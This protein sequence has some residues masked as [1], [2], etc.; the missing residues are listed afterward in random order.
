MGCC[1]S[2]VELATFADSKA[3]RTESAKE[4]AERQR[5]EGKAEAARLAKGEASASEEG[6]HAEYVPC[7]EHV[8]RATIPNV[9]FVIQI[10]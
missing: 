2:Q 3:N 9:S 1:V 4:R 6:K 8:F 7:I 10:L 5:E